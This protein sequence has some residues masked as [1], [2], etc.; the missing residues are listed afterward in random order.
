M[1]NRF[2]K[3]KTLY[4][5]AC[6][7]PPAERA[8][9]LDGVCQNDPALRARLD[10]LL[11]GHGQAEGFLTKVPLRETVRVAPPPREQGVGEPSAGRMDRYKLLEKIGEGGFGAVFVAAGGFVAGGV[12]GV[13]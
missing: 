9:F 13:V 6:K 8:A 11:E 10:L 1:D 3:I 5:Q 7:K 2:Q 12:A 4:D